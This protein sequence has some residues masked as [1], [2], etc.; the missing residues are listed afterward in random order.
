MV[1]AT[2]ASLDKPKEGA[3]DVLLNYKSTVCDA[4][5]LMK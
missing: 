3:G 5:A 1:G 4:V 2:P